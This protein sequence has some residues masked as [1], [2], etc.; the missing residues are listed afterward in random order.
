MAN[1]S[2]INGNPIVPSNGSVGTAQVARG[3][4][5]MTDDEKSKVDYLS[6]LV[7]SL[8]EQVAAIQVQQGGGAPV[9]L[10]GYLKSADAKATYAPKSHKHAMADVT[11]L[12]AA[13]DDA[14]SS[15]AELAK[16]LP[17]YYYT[18]VPSESSITE[19]PQLAV[20]KGG[21]VYL[22]E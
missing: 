12:Q 3:Y 7:D 18:D 17:I 10:V 14:E 8:V 1:I 15:I 11:G 2:S 20:I 13:L 4:N 21:A 6:Q 5:L 22:V 16:R 9:D 19:K